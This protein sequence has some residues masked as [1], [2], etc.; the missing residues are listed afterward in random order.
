MMIKKKK[1]MPKSILNTINE[2][3]VISESDNKSIEEKRRT[4][5]PL[6][7]EVADKM[8]VEQPV[9]SVNRS[10]NAYVI[11]EQHVVF[12]D[13]VLDKLNEEELKSVIAHELGHIKHKAF[14]SKVTMSNIRKNMEFTIPSSLFILE[15]IF[16][17][18]GYTSVPG[19]VVRETPLVLSAVGAN[20]VITYVGTMA[21]SVLS[22][23]HERKADMEAIK[24]YGPENFIRS[25]AAIYSLNSDLNPILSRYSEGLPKA[26][27]RVA[28]KLKYY[29][30]TFKSKLHHFVFGTHPTKIQ[31][32]KMA[33][34]YARKHPNETAIE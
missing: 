24:A 23:L 8:D 5:L 34:K 9:V 10:T 6:V 32:F 16:G 13:K 12:G 17:N 33:E 26:N 27:L 21:S 22:R 14:K 1:P 31:R 19:F 30:S 2:L 11:R 25:Q 15:N 3:K 28:E 20:Y 4:F 7:R 18:I 29:K